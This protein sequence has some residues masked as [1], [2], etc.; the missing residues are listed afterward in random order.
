MAAIAGFHARSPDA[1]YSRLYLTSDLDDYAD[2]WVG[3]LAHWEAKRSP[4]AAALATHWPVSTTPYAKSGHVARSYFTD[5]YNRVHVI[6]AA[7]DIGNLLSRQTLDVSVWNAHLVPKTLSAITESGTS[8]LT[9]SGITAP[10]TFAPLEERTFSVTV[11]INGPAV[12]SA[13]YTFDF[14]SEAPPLAVT[15]RRVIVFAH[16]PDWTKR[17]IEKY[18]WLTDVLDAYDGTEQRIALLGVPRRG[19]S[20][21]FNV[22]SEN[23]RVRL[24]NMLFGWQARIFAVPVWTEMQQL[25]AALPAGSTSVGCA[26]SGYEFAAGD[27]VVIWTAHD[28]HEALEIASVGASGL[29]FALPTINEWP[30]GAALLPI[31]LGRVKPRLANTREMAFY[32]S[33]QIDFAFEDHPG[34]PVA[35]TGDTYLGYRVHPQNPRFVPD[36]GREF[37]RKLSIFDHKTGSPWVKDQSDRLTLM[38]K[39]RWILRDRPEVAEFRSWLAARKGRTVPFWAESEG[40]DMEITATIA[41]AD[42]SI[43][44]RNIGYQRYLN[45]RADR[46]HIALRTKSGAV[47][48]RKILGATEIDD[49]TETLTLDAALGATIT[50]ADIASAR[51]MHL[52]RLESDSIEI[53]WH[54]LTMAESNAAIRSLPQ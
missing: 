14:G 21:S 44:I 2:D 43:Q 39:W 35:E 12:I 18:Q 17:V 32:M 33:Q 7:V 3:N 40:T 48:Y 34:W 9:E 36:T 19:L 8:G 50:P 26:T 30:A 4:G 42:I 54:T 46:R 6:P 15:G 47:Y 52:S 28:R 37:S 13:L 1:G 25:V 31:R 11:D 29:T 24:E 38:G 23:E 22:F 41:S 20:Y 16:E 10:T 45:G 5:Y 49:A 51:F 53:V 27:I